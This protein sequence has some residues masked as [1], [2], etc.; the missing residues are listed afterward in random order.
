MLRGL[1]RRI[2]ET[3]TAPRDL[4][5]FRV[6]AVSVHPEEP[7]DDE[8]YRPP[9]IISATPEPEAGIDPERFAIGALLFVEWADERLNDRMLALRLQA[10][11][12]RLRLA[13]RQGLVGPARYAEH[14]VRQQERYY[15]HREAA[16][17]EAA[18]H[19]EEAGLYIAV[20]R[21]VID[22][23][24]EADKTLL[25]AATLA[26]YEALLRLETAQSAEL[27]AWLERATTAWLAGHEAAFPL[28]AWAETGRLG[29][30]ER[31]D[32]PAQ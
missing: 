7:K 6:Q 19:S 17:Y 20:K 10:L 2:N 5:T 13:V 28:T 4:L 18:L 8:D 24:W 29:E 32:R 27:L 9:L 15:L 25:E 31:D 16:T 12:P 14:R 1:R 23:P 30:P 26:P 21:R 22:G 11:L 3:R